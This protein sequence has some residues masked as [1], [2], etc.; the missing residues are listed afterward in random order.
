MNESG[1]GTVDLMR[2][3]ISEARRA[4]GKTHP[5]PAVGAVISHE[6]RLVACGHTQ[7]VGGDHAEIMALKAFR[8]AGHVANASTRFVVTMEP[9]STHGRTGACTEAILSSGIRD[10]VI[11]TVDPNPA[12]NGRGIDLLREAGLTVELGVCGDAC[13]DLNLIFNWRMERGEP[14][15][16][17]KIA[18]TID[19][20]IAT[21]GG[22]S[23]WVTG[24]EAR[25][26]VHRWRRYFPAIGVGAGTI[27]ADDPSLTSRMEGEAP[28]CPMRFVFDRNLVCLNEETPRVFKDEWRER[29]IVVT[30]AANREKAARLRDRRGIQFWEMED[31]DAESGFRSFVD[32][33]EAEGVHGVYLEGG[34]HLLSFFLEYQ[35]IHYLFAYRSPKVMGDTKALAPFSGWEPFSM[36]ETMTLAEVRHET[37][38]EDQLMRGFMQYPEPGARG[39]RR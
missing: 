36:Q 5:N 32:R 9:C 7:P 22:L 38:G 19:G 20:R 35:S 39:E 30:S 2:R 25:A 33:C 12:H 10:I 8:E 1:T 26:D 21:R 28:W 29:T 31:T 6:D 3:A 15:F 27:I 24:T 14:F 17:A 37:F 11:G 16:A 23:K 13:R 4:M 18:T 34:A